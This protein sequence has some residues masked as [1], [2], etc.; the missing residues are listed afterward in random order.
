MLA[1][2]RC[3]CSSH[4]NN[5]VKIYKHAIDLKC[6]MTSSD[7]LKKVASIEQ[8]FLEAAIDVVL[9]CKH[10]TDI[11]GVHRIQQMILKGQ[12]YTVDEE[13]CKISSDML[14]VVAK[15]QQMF[16]EVSTDV[17]LWCKHST[18]VVG[19]HRIKPILCIGKNIQQI[20]WEVLSIQRMFLE[21]ASI[22][23]ILWEVVSIQLMLLEVASIQQLLLMFLKV[24]SIQQ[25]LWEV[26][27]IQLMF[28][29]VASI[30]FNKYCGKL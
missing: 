29:E 27:S 8:V 28:L 14:W 25:I 7:M 16:L 11:V 12:K 23:Q 17:V 15:I 22:Q 13:H 2:N 26:V 5:V 9:R 4:L 30:Q 6:F 19:V 18:D 1:F 21:V 10:W 3:G 24:A 20:L